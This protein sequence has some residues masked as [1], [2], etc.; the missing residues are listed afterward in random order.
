[1]ALQSPAHEPI[2]KL[3][4]KSFLGRFQ[5]RLS[6]VTITRSGATPASAATSPSQILARP[7]HG[8]ITRH[9]DIKSTARSAQCV[10]KT[11]TPIGARCARTGFS[12]CC[13][14]ELTFPKFPFFLLLFFAKNSCRFWFCISF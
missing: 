5:C 11:P 14:G 12:C 7:V 4:S 6:G 13:I 3:E 8:S 1:M 10:K 9:S 2:K